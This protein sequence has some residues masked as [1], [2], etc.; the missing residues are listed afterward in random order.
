MLAA[1]SSSHTLRKSLLQPV[2]PR[3]SST[4][5]L[6]GRELRLLSQQ[7]RGWS[8]LHGMRDRVGEVVLEGREGCRTRRRQPKRSG[9]GRLRT[10]LRRR[11]SPSSARP[12]GALAGEGVAVAHAPLAAL[13]KAAGAC[14]RPAVGSQS[15]VGGSG[16][17]GT[18]TA[19]AAT[20]AAAA[21][22]T[23]AAALGCDC[24]PARAEVH[25]ARAAVTRAGRTTRRAVSACVAER[26]HARAIATQSVAAAA[27]QASPRLACQA[28]VP[29]L[30]LAFWR[31]A[32]AAASRRA[33]SR[34]AASKHAASKHAAEQPAC[35]LFDRLCRGNGRDVGLRAPPVARAGRASA[36]IVSARQ[37]AVGP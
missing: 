1:S 26:A 16:A 3:G 14:S 8:A 7:P 2:P 18:K 12:E 30:A 25:A 9:C 34:H 21:S 17:A 19:A 20:A 4:L 23:N 35:S 22:S 31:S 10:E 5:R 33:A 24:T 36:A 37:R 13:R 29:G 32:T 11:R 6:L 28:R 15:S 27:H